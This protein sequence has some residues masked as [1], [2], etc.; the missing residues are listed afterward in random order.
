MAI[1]AA[2]GAATVVAVDP[3]AAHI[4]SWSKSRNGCLYVGGVNGFDSYAYTVKDH[5]NCAGH[6]WLRVTFTNGTSSGEQHAAGAV[7]V[8][9]P[10]RSAWHRSQSVESWGQS[11]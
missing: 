10:I 1:V 2:V 6:A 8:Y 11:H 7:E 4:G 9:G 5:G 3:A